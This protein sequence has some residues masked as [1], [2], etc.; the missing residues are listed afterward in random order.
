MRRGDERNRLS[1]P[2]ERGELLARRQAEAQ[3]RVGRLRGGVEWPA[4]P[5]E[6]VL[7]IEG[8][9]RVAQ[10]GRTA[11]GRDDGVPRGRDG[12][13]RPAGDVNR[14]SSHDQRPSCVALEEVT[15]RGGVPAQHD[16]VR[17]ARF[18][19]QGVEC[20]LVLARRELLRPRED[21]RGNGA[22]FQR[23]ACDERGEVFHR[24]G[25]ER[26]GA[27]F[28]EPGR[29]GE[30]RDGVDP[31]GIRCRGHPLCGGH[32]IRTDDKGGRGGTGGRG[33]SA[34]LRIGGWRREKLPELARLLGRGRRHQYHVPA[35]RE[36]SLHLVQR[37]TVLDYQGAGVRKGC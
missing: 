6:G 24:A 27:G 35:A 32:V 37:H 26:D 31:N 15:K 3:D 2:G 19:E 1:E 25:E 28:E 30:P 13:E 17:L 11:G 33:G 12:R 16:A 20:G 9:E 21:D 5:H 18:A 8:V 36:R 14:R 22:E 4:F 29:A 7:G 34:G 23:R 10:R